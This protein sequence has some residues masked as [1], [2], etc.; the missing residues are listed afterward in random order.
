MTKKEALQVWYHEFGDKEY[1]YD[2]NGRKIKRD[3]YLVENQVGWVIA[4]MRPLEQGGLDDEG[5]TIILHHNTAL[6]KGD[7]YP[8]FTVD[9]IPYVVRMSDDKTYYYIE[10]L[11]KKSEEYQK[12]F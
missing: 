8:Y 5:N 10:K 11:D 7:K 3:D 4:Y 9:E 12:E 2:F 6:E 1:A